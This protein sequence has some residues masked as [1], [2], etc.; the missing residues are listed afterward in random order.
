M[1]GMPGPEAQDR[2]QN[3]RIKVLAYTNCSNSGRQYNK[4]DTAAPPLHGCNAGVGPG[5]YFEKAKEAQKTGVIRGILFHQGESDA[6]SQAWVGKAKE[7]A[8]DLRK[9]LGLGD[10]TPFLAG[11]LL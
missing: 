1:E 9:D 2:V 8:A 7:V 4:W 5:D 11:E 6:G 3:P 10:S